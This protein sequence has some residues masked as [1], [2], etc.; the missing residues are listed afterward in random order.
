MSGPARNPWPW[1]LA[2]AAVDTATQVALKYASLSLGDR[3]LGFGFVAAAAV[4]PQVWIAVGC[5]LA[6]LWVWMAVLA[7]MDLS[8]AFPANGLAYVTM[9][10]VAW[11]L[12]DEVIGAERAL[13][14]AIILA[15][16]L[17]LGTEPQTAARAG[18]TLQKEY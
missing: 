14:I 5:Y 2:F 18:T 15:G 1:W 13:G 6:T 9:P 12:F 10:P 16:V 11:L 8:H 7:R 3:P 4:S 17:V